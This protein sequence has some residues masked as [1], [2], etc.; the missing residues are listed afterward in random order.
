[1]FVV[2]N[3]LI[4]CLSDT[5]ILNFPFFFYHIILRFCFRNS[6]LL[7]IICFFFQRSKS[8]GSYGSIDSKFMFAASIDSEGLAHTATESEQ[9][10][11]TMHFPRSSRQGSCDGS[12]ILKAAPVSATVSSGASSIDLFQSPVVASSSSTLG[13]FQP[14]AVSSTSSV[15]ACK[16]SQTLAA[17]SLDIST[18]AQSKSTVDVKS[19]EFSV[20]N[21]EGWATFDSPQPSASTGNGSVDPANM[22]SKNEGSLGK[23]NPF[24]PSGESIQW[25]SY[26]NSSFHGPYSSTS[27][28]WHDS[29][30]DGVP[31][32]QSTPV[33][34][35]VNL[36][37]LSI[38]FKFGEGE[39]NNSSVYGR[40]NAFSVLL[41]GVS[42]LNFLS[43]SGW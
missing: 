13:L 17:S 12:D 9:T 24:S 37:I 28:P 16:F 20:S 22:L 41:C 6:S 23:L 8:S 5:I 3:T 33:C 15:D 2:A 21:D 4:I 43:K 42:I 29:L 7:Q 26:E 35:S 36:P 40:V 34:F 31:A 1:M 11:K 30:H 39:T 38:Y 19:T 25:P 10:A 14:L 27:S 18:A 32:T